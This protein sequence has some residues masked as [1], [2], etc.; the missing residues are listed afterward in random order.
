M[1]FFEE[2]QRKASNA[3]AKALE[4]TKGLSDAA[5][6]RVTIKEEE[7]NIGDLFSRLGQA[8]YSAHRK[9]PDDPFLE[10]IQRI[11]FSQAK[12]TQCKQQISIIKNI[13][14]CENCGAEVP[15]DSFYCSVCHTPCSGNYGK[16][17]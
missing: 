4:M 12:I 16:R 1:A 17:N 9:D 10:L 15:N 5:T 13:H 8:Y 2:L 14:Y 7:K 11:Q 6:L 3:G